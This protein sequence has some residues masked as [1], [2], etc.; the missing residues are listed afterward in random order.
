MKKMNFKKTF[1]NNRVRCAVLIALSMAGMTGCGQKEAKPGQALVRVNGEEITVL[2]LNEELQRSG[3]TASQQDEASKQLLETLIDRQLLQSEAA[4][5]K[6]DR[7]P[8]VMQAIER[9]KALIVAQVYMQKRMANLAKPTRA[10]IEAYFLKHPEYFSQRKQFDMKQ[11]VIATADLDGKLKTAIESSKSLDEVAAW[12]TSNQVKFTRDQLSRTSS[13][14]APELSAKLLAMSKGQMFIIKDGERSMVIVLSDIKDSPVTLDVA[15]GQIEQY[16][17]NAKN[18]EAA[19][20]ELKRLRAVAKIE[21]LH[22]PAAAAPV[23]PAAAATP[24]AI[25]AGADKLAAAALEANQ[26]GVAGMK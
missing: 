2:Q 5:E 10:E 19:D 18:K 8:R 9:A 15:A 6:T 21:Y 16:L 14:L 1:T 17:F 3:A 4:K 22:K 23:T 20:A 12:M 13:D 26:R 7:D 11:L 25:P 24:K